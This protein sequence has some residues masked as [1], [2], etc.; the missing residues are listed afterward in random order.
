[1]MVPLALAGGGSYRAI[2][3]SLHARTNAEVIA[4]FLSWRVELADGKAAGT[5]V[6]Y[7]S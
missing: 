3:A 2:K 4:R 5:V 1:M 7:R 6:G